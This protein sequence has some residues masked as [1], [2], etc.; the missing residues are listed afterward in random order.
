MKIILKKKKDYSTRK[1]ESG[2]WYNYSVFIVIFN[3]YNYLHFVISQFGFIQILLWIIRTSME[4]RDLNLFNKNKI[5]NK[6][7][8]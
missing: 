8:I 6:K 7:G 5:F 3:Y 2:V 4:A 1:V